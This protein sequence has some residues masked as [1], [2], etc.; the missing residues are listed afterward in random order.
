[1][2]PV[3]ITALLW[4]WFLPPVF[5]QNL[6]DLPPG[7]HYI[8]C[9][10]GFTGVF[11]DYGYVVYQGYEWDSSWRVT[12]AARPIPPRAW[13]APPPG[14]TDL[15]S[16]DGRAK[17]KNAQVEVLCW[18]Y[19]VIDIT[20]YHYDPIRFAG[21][22][23]PC[24][25]GSGSGPSITDPAGYDPYSSYAPTAETCSDQYNAGDSSGGGGSGL[26]CEWQYIYIDESNDGGL[27]WTEI[28]EGWAQVC[29]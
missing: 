21:T 25:G 27:T 17:W 4:M 20:A 15:I 24:T 19:A 29:G 1:M 14:T 3:G 18:V 9:P 8:E 2:K 11:H 23:V 26:T 12:T 5:A 6:P 7:G 13:Y 28:W 22:V 16:T 10:S